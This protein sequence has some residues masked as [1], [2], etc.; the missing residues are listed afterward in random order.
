MPIDLT[1]QDGPNPTYFLLTTQFPYTQA[2]LNT[3][4][5]TAYEILRPKFPNILEVLQQIPNISA[6]DIQKLDEKIS[7]SASTKGNKI[8]KAKKDLFKKIT[9]HIAGRSV[10]QQGKKE[11]RIL[12]L[13]PIVPPGGRNSYS[14]L[15]DSA[16]DTG[17]AHLF[18]S[19]S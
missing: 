7:L 12:N 2:A 19:R 18:A 9:S 5:V 6:A 16:Q 11:V 17:L 15:T 8:D 1:I 3:L 10:G 4:G 14:N 13:P